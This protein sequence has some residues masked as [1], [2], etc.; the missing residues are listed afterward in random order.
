MIKTKVAFVEGRLLSKQSKQL[1][2]DWKS[3][4]WLEKSPKKSLLFRAC[5]QA[6]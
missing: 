5:K 1:K 4:D 2:K 6:N 3:F